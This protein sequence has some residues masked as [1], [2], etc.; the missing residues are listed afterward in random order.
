MIDTIR[1]RVKRPKLLPGNRLV[2][3]PSAVQGTKLIHDRVVEVLPPGDP[4]PVKVRRVYLHEDM[5]LVDSFANYMMISFQMP[6]ILSLSMNNVSP[7]TYREAVLVFDYVQEWLREIAGVDVD[8]MEAGVNR[9]DL[10]QNAPSRFS[11]EDYAPLF[12]LLNLKRQARKRYEGTYYGQSVY[13][14][15]CIYNKGQRTGSY[16]QDVLGLRSNLIRWEVRLHRA[17]T[18]QRIFGIYTVA[19]LLDKWDHLRDRKSVV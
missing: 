5:I 15:T 14:T 18:I 11:F 16:N 3:V 13:R 10:F 17:Q 2:I 12:E 1:L 4:R 7:V 9:L 8:I 6:Q 19:D